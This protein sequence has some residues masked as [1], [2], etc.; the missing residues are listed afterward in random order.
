MAKIQLTKRNYL[1]TGDFNVF[2]NDSTG[3]KKYVEIDS[4]SYADL[5]DATIH[6]LPKLDGYTWK[7]AMGG[8]VKTDSPDI[9]LKD[10]EYCEFEGKYIC[11]L[12]MDYGADAPRFVDKSAIINDQLDD[13][14]L[15]LWQ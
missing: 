10:K 8:A 13:S 12:R 15:Y 11:V 4:T 1:G 14:Y 7:S 3:E 5:A 6:E 2:I 9:F